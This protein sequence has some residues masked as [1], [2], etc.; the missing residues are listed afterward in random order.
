MA[1]RRGKTIRRRRG[2]RGGSTQ[3]GGNEEEDDMEEGGNDAIPIEQSQLALLL[4]FIF[5]FILYCV[6]VCT[7]PR[8]ASPSLGKYIYY[9]TTYV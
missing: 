4:S 1:R 6:Y 2:R 8:K 9:T 3:R 7:N 5:I